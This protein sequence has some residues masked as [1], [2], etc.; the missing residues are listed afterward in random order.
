MQASTSPENNRN[1]GIITGA[2]S[3]IGCSL[4][5]RLSERFDHLYILGRNISN[6]EKANDEIIKYGD[7]FL[8]TI[9]QRIEDAGKYIA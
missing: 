2:S 3:G 6:L 5:I 4:A 9:P 8:N 1:V 7:E